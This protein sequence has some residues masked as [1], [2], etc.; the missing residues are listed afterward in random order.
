MNRQRKDE[1]SVYGL[2]TNKRKWAVLVIIS[3]YKMQVTSKAFE[4]FEITAID[5]EM[6]Q[7][8][9]LCM[10]KISSVDVSIRLFTYVIPISMSK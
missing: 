8:K 2:W 9:F 6:K 3:N 4:M 1:S 10:E 5:E 7:G